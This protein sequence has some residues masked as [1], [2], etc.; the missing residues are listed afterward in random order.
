[1]RIRKLRTF[2]SLSDQPQISAEVFGCYVFARFCEKSPDP[3]CKIW[4]IAE[5]K[6]KIKK[7]EF[8][9]EKTIKKKN[10]NL[11]EKIRWSKMLQKITTKSICFLF[12]N[13]NLGRILKQLHICTPEAL[14]SKSIFKI[15]RRSKTRKYRCYKID[16]LFHTL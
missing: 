11:N 8:I 2:S 12:C 5:I 6:K 3:G 10:F 15:S 7:L 13:R 16:F 1:M 4:N 9:E 14:R